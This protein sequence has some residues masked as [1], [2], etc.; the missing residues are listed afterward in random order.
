MKIRS[1]GADLF[2][3]D[4]RTEG[5]QQDRHDKP[6]WSLFANLQTRRKTYVIFSVSSNYTYL[7]NVIKGR[8]HCLI[9]II[10][11]YFSF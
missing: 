4:G 2:H 10:S 5:I 1:V 11:F 3:S 7:K 8:L 9:K 6:K